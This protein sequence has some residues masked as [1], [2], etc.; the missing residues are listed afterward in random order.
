MPIKGISRALKPHALPT[1]TVSFFLADLRATWCLLVTG[2]AEP[3]I[4]YLVTRG[5]Q[6]FQPDSKKSREILDRKSVPP[7]QSPQ[8]QGW[9]WEHFS[10][11]T[12]SLANVTACVLLVLLT[13]AFFLLS[14][15]L[16]L[17]CF[18]FKVNIYHQGSKGDFPQNHRW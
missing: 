8:G 9:D 6:S 2:R 16:V 17:F 15:F 3:T 10:K 13:R 18:V 12:V 1:P 5:K 11:Q 4:N 14:F 7:S